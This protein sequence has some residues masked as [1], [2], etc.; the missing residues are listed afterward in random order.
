MIP[1]TR[2]RHGRQSSGFTLIEL[3]TALLILCLLALLSY[4]GLEAVLGTQDRIEAESKKWRSVAAFIAR[5]QQDVLLAAPRSVRTAG[6]TAAPWQAQD[7]AGTGPRLEF[8]RFAAAEGVDTARRLAYGLNAN[9]EIELWVW[10][11]LDV[12]PNAAPARYPLLEGVDT[13]ELRYLDAARNW[14]GSWP[15]SGTSAAIPRAVRLRLVLSSGE[16][17]V[18]IFA[19]HS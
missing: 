4:R 3:L 6:G 18:R 9:R 17:I 11:G 15:A 5:F 12:A 8:S 13:F 19:L 14:V 1:R 2:L 7:T 10:P 16:E